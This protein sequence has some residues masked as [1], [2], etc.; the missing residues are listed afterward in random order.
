MLENI[1]NL[2]LGSSGRFRQL[3]ESA[4]KVLVTLTIAVCSLPSNDASGLEGQLTNQASVPLFRLI[5]DFLLLLIF[6]FF[7][8]YIF[9]VF[10]PSLEAGFIL[11]R[12]AKGFKPSQTSNPSQPRI[13]VSGGRAERFVRSV[14]AYFGIFTPSDQPIGLG[15]IGLLMYPELVRQTASGETSSLLS[16]I[17]SP[18]VVIEVEIVYMLYL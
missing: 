7:Y 14:F 5:P 10:L 3:T 4:V 8:W 17:T 1:V 11:R 16:D 6:Y 12:I 15:P 2:L 13:S 9:Y 18:F